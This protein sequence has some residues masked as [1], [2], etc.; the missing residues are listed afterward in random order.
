MTIHWLLVGVPPEQDDNDWVGPVIIISFFAWF[1]YYFILRQIS[2]S[3]EKDDPDLSVN[4][5]EFPITTRYSERNLHLAYIVLAA[6][7]MMQNR[8]A[9]KDK[10]GFLAKYFHHHFPNS[11]LDFKQTLVDVFRS[12][13]T[14]KS[15]AI[16]LNRHMETESEKLKVIHFLA[17]LAMVD[18][19]IRREE[20]LVLTVIARECHIPTA[21]IE[22]VIQMYNRYEEAERE[23]DKKEFLQNNIKSKSTLAF[24]ILG[25]PKESDFETVKKKYRSLVKQYHPDRLIEASEE[26]RKIAE[27]KFIQIQKAYEILETLL[28]QS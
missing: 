14:V 22:E 26:D 17:G 8:Q 4:D 15:T 18:G 27:Q 13:V 21:S 24:E 10:Q 6:R 11:E 9:F 23:Q 25:L 1:V 12:P 3:K 5:G 7:I 2:K 28:K 19:D 16:W 20:K